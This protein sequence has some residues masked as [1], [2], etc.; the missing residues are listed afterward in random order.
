M[1][2]FTMPQLVISAALGGT[3]AANVLCG[4]SAKEAAKCGTGPEGSIEVP[5]SV[6]RKA[7]HRL[8]G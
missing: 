5:Q 3:S 1:G 2:F 8:M 7:V 6:R 4:T